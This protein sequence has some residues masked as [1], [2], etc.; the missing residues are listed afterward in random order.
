[1][2]LTVIVLNFIGYDMN[3]LTGTG[4]I[5]AIGMIVDNSIVIL[6]SCF[7]YRAQS[8]SF[9]EAAAEGTGSMLMSILAGTL[10][11]VVVYIP[12]SI[13]KGMSGMMFG[14]LLWTIILTLLASFLCAVV[15]VPLSFTLLTP[16]AKEDIPVNRLLRKFQNFYRRVVPKLLRKP[17]KVMLI[18]VGSFLAA[19]LLADENFENVTLSISDDSASF[20]VYAVDHC[21]RSS[22]KA[23]ELYTTEFS[24]YPG[25]D[26]S[27]TPTS[28]TSGMSAMGSTGNTTTVML[29][30]DDMDAL[31]QGAEQVRELMA[32]TPGVL[33][34]ENPFD[35]SRVK[36]HLEIDPQRAQNAGTTPAAISM[37]IRYLL[38][39]LTAATVDDGD[40]EYDIVL[41][42]LKGKY[43][44][45]MSVM[46]YPIR[47][48]TGKLVTL[49]DVA[50]V[51]YDSTL[52][53]LTRQ[54]GDYAVTLTATTT[55]DA[56]YTAAN[57]ISAAAETLDFPEGVSVGTDARTSMQDDEL[58]TMVNALLASLFLVFLVMTVQFNSVKMSIMVMICIPLCLIGSF[59]LVFLTGRPMS[60]FGLM[61]FMML[62]G[63]SVNNGIYL[64][65]G[66]TQLR[67]TM[68]LEQALIEA[69]TTRLRPIL[70]TTLTTIISMIP[71]IFTTSPNLVMMKE[72]S[73][74]VIGG[75][76]ASTVL[77]MFLVPPF[78][79]LMR[80]ERVDGSKRPPLF[81]KKNR[82]KSPVEA[83]LSAAGS[84]ADEA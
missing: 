28:S 67:Q 83:A 72:M 51:T 81:K 27:V 3:V 14:P 11:T 19:I 77:A 49:H 35:Q 74:I 82:E 33:R 68:P 76:I 70:M 20:T 39:G 48:Q 18:G 15:V 45:V 63:I 32:Q 36:G 16:K 60:M 46:D 24:N 56:K 69:G 8:L 43:E 44:D 65:D 79:L 21:N 59:T 64:V 84:N 13:S 30:G 80:G 53:V 5:L 17:G 6:E 10:T 62:I 66:T 78:Y 54:D 42:Y 57:A 50:D 26:V 61:G 38:N 12:L 7:R 29:L 1:M 71:M 2:L 25:M 55:D 52:P 22:E 75:L 37:Q 4:L 31:R 34:V 41:E 9:Q 40:Q 73:Y 23:A 58:S 47:T